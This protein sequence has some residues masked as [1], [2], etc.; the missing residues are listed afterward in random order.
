VLQLIAD[1]GASAV[2]HQGDFDYDDDPEAW[3]AQIDAVLGPFFPYFASVGNHDVEFF[4]AF[5]GYLARL[6]ARMLRVGLD[7]SGVLGAQSALEYKGLFVV[8]TAPGIFGPG[9]GFY[10][11]YIEEEL[12]ADD[13]IWR[14]SSWHKNQ[15]LMQV[16]GKLSETGWGVYEESRR[17]GA[18]IATG[19]EHSYSRTHLLSS[20]EDQLVASTDDTLTLTRDD[21]GTPADEGESFA[22][23]SG[24]GGRSIRDQELS[25][26]WWASIYTS[27]QGAT[28]GALFGVFNY[29]GDPRLARF[30]FKAID[31]STVDEFFV[32]STLGTD[33]VFCGDVNLDRFL[34][35]SDI[36]SVRASL[37]DPAGMPLSAGG[38]RRC[39]VLGE[40]GG[41]GLAD[42]TVL[43]RAVEGPGLAPGIAQLC[44]AAFDL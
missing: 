31:G 16:G 30:Y 43:R 23:V 22:F 9:N 10:D 15:R 21:P 17:G 26:D 25:G 41:C 6:A 32:R 1:E 38:Q 7:W 42:L 14:I 28:F 19:H 39:P 29:R 12:D 24:L 35:A 36:Q 13:S 2:I 27:T 34:D 8:L 33:P 5:D 37:A 40:T 20:F 18:I 3:E 11:D 44:A 4:F